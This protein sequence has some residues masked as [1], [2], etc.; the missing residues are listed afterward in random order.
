MIKISHPSYRVPFCG[1]VT[2]RILKNNQ[3]Q[4]PFRKDYYIIDFF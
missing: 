2:R 3:Q 4:V 1:F